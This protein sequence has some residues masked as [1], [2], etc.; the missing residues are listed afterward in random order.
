MGFDIYS[1]EL[2]Q[3]NRQIAVLVFDKSSVF[4][5]ALLVHSQIE[6]DALAPW[7][8][9]LV[10]YQI[11]TICDDLQVPFLFPNEQLSTLLINISLH[12]RCLNFY[13]M[14]ELTMS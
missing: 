5:L 2:F 11:V 7:R 10:I 9:R 6:L 12:H 8:L 4:P 14:K 13:N 3:I 1:L